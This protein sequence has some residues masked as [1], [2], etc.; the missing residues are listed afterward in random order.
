MVE[1]VI[2][3]L[4]ALGTGAAGAAALLI[5]NRLLLR[6]ERDDPGRTHVSR[7]LIMLGLTLAVVALVL[8][9]LPVSDQT[10][11][12]LIGLLG[13]ALTAAITLSSATFVGNIMAGLMLRSVA[14]MR[15]GD[16]IRV[17]DH[18]GRVTVL[19]LFH[20]EIQ[21]AD[22]D[23]TT[24]P[25]LYLVSTPVTV[26]NDSGTIVSCEVSLGYDNNHRQLEAL[27]IQAAETAGLTDPFVH[28]TDLGDFSVRYRVAGFL[29]EIKSLLGTR[30]NLR[31]GLLDALHG[32]GVEIMSPQ[33]VGHRALDPDSRIIAKA[34][35]AKTKDPTATES[36]EVLAFDKADLGDP[37][38]DTDYALCI[39][40]QTAS[41]PS[42]AAALDIAPGIAWTDK[43]PKGLLYKDKTATGDGVNIAKF[44]PGVAGKTL[45]Q[46]KAKGANVP[47]PVSVSSE[48][49]M[50][51]DP[52][53]IV[54]LRNGAG[55][56]LHT[57]FA[58]EHTKKND[59]TN[60]QA[61]R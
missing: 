50:T 30:S 6:R 5:G 9:S 31:K 23:L 22:R 27:L 49:T 19:G 33:I 37:T 34:M 60:F 59:G 43:S 13:L 18:F 58:P 39:W 40:D 24:L 41:V 29:A 42:L 17:A 44:K 20:T 47:V 36:A 4:P 3:I 7:H 38:V 57:E 28:V 15:P 21:T 12:Q 46:V 56:C 54:Q 51:Q 1:L 26:I 25:N 14:N 2:Q 8:V 61:K 55:L 32:A 11:G 48:V 53:V 52:S 16:T 10:R 35:P 45:A